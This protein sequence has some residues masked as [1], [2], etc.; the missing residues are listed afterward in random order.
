LAASVVFCLNSSSAWAAAISLVTDATNAPPVQHG[1]NKLKLALRDKG[2]DLE[3]ARTAQ[4]S[5]LT[6]AARGDMRIVAG[7]ASS[8]GPAATL[9][10]TLKLDVPTEPE[11]LLIHQEASQGRKTLLITSADPRGLMYALLDVADRVG[12]AADAKNPLSEVRDAREKPAV[13]E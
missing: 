7:L 13:S 3:E 5:V 9:L 2:V 11:A 10:K 4:P 12:W 1:L 6:E 8:A